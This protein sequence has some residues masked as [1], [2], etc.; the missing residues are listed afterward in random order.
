MNIDT[1]IL[2]RVQ[3]TELEILREIDRICKKNNV[4][5][6]LL[7]GTL[8]GAIRHNGFIPWDDDIDICMSRENYNL[9]IKACKEDLND[10]YMLHNQS[11]DNL[12]WLPF[13][14]IRKKGTVY[15]QEVQS[16]F[17]SVCDGVW[18]DVFPLDY[19]K[20]L[21]SAKVK[22][23]LI[24]EIRAV[25]ELRLNPELKKINFC[26]KIIIELSKVLTIKRLIRLQEIIMISKSKCRYFKNYGSPYSPE[27]ELWPVEWVFPVVDH[28]FEDGIFP[29]S[30]GWHEMLTKQYG[31]YMKLPPLEKRVTHAPV[32]VKL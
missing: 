6:A 26:K 16:K 29:I 4:Q 5:Y 2:R 21:K 28:K 12:Y 7:G 20:G 3:L 15:K 17:Y 23:W 11:T 24:G 13:L 18:V 10:K 22:T 30:N 27:K 31:D 19:V 8:L 1:E 14:K 9:F 25:I 32:E